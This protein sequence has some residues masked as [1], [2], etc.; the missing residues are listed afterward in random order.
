[1]NIESINHEL[2]LFISF[3]IMV[4]LMLAI[5]LG[6]LSREKNHTMSIKRAGYWTLIWISTAMLFALFIY[7]Y[8]TNP[9]DP[10]LSKTKALEYIAAYLLE[11]SLSVDNLFVFIMI[12]QKYKIGPERQ[13]DILKWGILGAVILRAIMILMGAALVSQFTWILYVFG[14]FLIYTAV[15]MFMHKEDDS[16]EEFN[17]ET[18][19]TFRFLRKLVPM[20][21]KME[22]SHFFIK[23][24][25]RLFATPMFVVLVLIELSDVMFAFDSIPAVF[26][27]SQSPFIV[28]TSNIFAILGLR[29]LY[30]MISGVM[31]I[32]EHLQTGVSVILGFVGIKMLLPLASEYLVGNLVSLDSM[33]VSHGKFHVPISISLSVIIGILLLSILASLPKYLKNKDGS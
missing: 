23:K 3:N 30:F 15:K 5:D 16:E 14:V 28:Y 6:L 19:R 31:G 17:P 2:L 27:V 11:K 12:F 22:G 9:E 18:S 4:V 25:G 26:S 32:F 29:S 33:W 24:E 8:D 7:L 13:P 20:T 21:E 10:S 1:M